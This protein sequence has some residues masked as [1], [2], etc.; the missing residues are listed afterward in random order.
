[1]NK[2]LWINPV[3]V[4]MYGRDV[5]F[6]EEELIKKGY[7]IVNCEPQLDYV[8]NQYK[9]YSKSCKNTILD[10][11]CPETIRVLKENNLT[12]NYDVPDIEPILIRTARVLYDKYVKNSNDTL[13]ITCPCT[14]LRDF[15][16]RKLKDKKEVTVLTW[17]EFIESEDMKSLGKIDSSPI[18]LGFFDDTFKDVLKL[19]TEE[20]IISNISKLKKKYDI[21]EMLYCK[22]GC[23]NGDGL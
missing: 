4:K 11:R 5:K 6:I 20:E 19:S 9:T 3:A 17:K 8:K 1:M 2:Y 7:I 10:C 12:T 23:N 15:T 18:P 22:D 13:I 14:Q 21:I 16:S